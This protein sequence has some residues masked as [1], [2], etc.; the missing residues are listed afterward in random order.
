MSAGKLAQ[1]GDEEDPAD[2][3]SSLSSPQQKRLM[4]AAKYFCGRARMEAADL[5]QE[6]ML[7]VLTGE[8]KLKPGLD[9]VTF[10]CG[11]MK[12]ISSG[13]VQKRKVRT[14]VGFSE[15]PM[16]LGLFS[17]MTPNGDPTPESA[18]IEQQTTQEC[19]EAFHCWLETEFHEDEE[20]L[21]VLYA[22]FE[23]LKGAELCEATGI[24]K[25]KLATI[26]RRIARKLSEFQ[27][28]G[29]A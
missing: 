22:L 18:L 1:I 9:R 15:Q 16:D 8:R 2:V 13:E 24:T 19:D 25:S 14:K 3:L 6:A 7:R 28:R 26:R 27:S 11:I 10:L 5:L 21:I 23:G 12:S 17:D 20:T 29:A 4:L